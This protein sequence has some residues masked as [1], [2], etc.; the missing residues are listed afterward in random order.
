[1]F[2]GRDAHAYKG[3]VCSGRYSYCL[4]GSAFVDYLIICCDVL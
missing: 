3:F 1:M 4:S 2:Y